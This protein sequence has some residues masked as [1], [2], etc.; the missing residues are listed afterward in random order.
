MVHSIYFHPI[1][2]A[3]RLYF[4]SFQNYCKFATPDFHLYPTSIVPGRVRSPAIQI[5]PS[6]GSPEGL[7]FA[8]NRKVHQLM[9]NFDIVNLTKIETQKNLHQ[10]SLTWCNQ[11]DLRNQEFLFGNLEMQHT[12]ELGVDELR[13][14]NININTGRGVAT[15]ICKSAPHIAFKIWRDQDHLVVQGRANYICLGWI[16]S[17][18][19]LKQLAR[20]LGSS[21]LRR[22][23]IL[24]YNTTD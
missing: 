17:V 5:I 10:R 3:H 1:S 21:F 18:R 7:Y 22:S 19:C 24:S 20:P 4:L 2:L 9:V 8:P 12:T 11:N 15:A 23:K 13:Q 16:L 6:E 14:L